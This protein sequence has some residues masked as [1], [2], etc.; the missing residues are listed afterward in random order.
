MLE[1][2]VLRLARHQIMLWRSEDLQKSRRT[3][4]YDA[5]VIYIRFKLTGVNWNVP[6]T[7][8]DRQMFHAY[9]DEVIDAGPAQLTDEEFE[10]LDR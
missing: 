8:E 1:T 10:L 7:P 6:F 4:L 9:A 3:K 5:L 2:R